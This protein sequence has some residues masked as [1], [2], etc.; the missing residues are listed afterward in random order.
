MGVRNVMTITTPFPWREQY[1][2][3]LFETDSERLPMRIISAQ[4][5]LIR[6]A[7]ELFLKPGDHFE[8]EQ[9]IDEALRALRALRKCSQS[10]MKRTA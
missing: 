1:Q 10:R 3:V 6:R 7:R 9:A 2:A 8:G 4:Q 5:A